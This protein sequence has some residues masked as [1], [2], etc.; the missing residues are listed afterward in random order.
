MEK[1]ME[2]MTPAVYA[3]VGAVVVGILV[4]TLG[5]LVPKLVGKSIDTRFEKKDREEQEY[6]KEQIE[7]ALRQQEGQQVMTDSLLVILRHMITGN[8]VEDLQK[9]QKNLEDFQSKNERAMRLK[10]IKYNLR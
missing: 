2:A 8:H 10:A 4:W 1:A 5:W 9:A 3:V 6:R 7:D